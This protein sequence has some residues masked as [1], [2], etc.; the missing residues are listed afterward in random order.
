[1][2]EKNSSRF[3]ST[4]QEGNTEQANQDNV[5]VHKGYSDWDNGSY[6][7]VTGNQAFSY[8]KKTSFFE[9]YKGLLISTLIAVII[10]VSLGVI[11]LKIFIDLDPEEVTFQSGGQ[12]NGQTV[13][14][15]AEGNGTES[16]STFASQSFSFF[17]TQAG[18]FSEEAK[19]QELVDRLQGAEIKSVTWVEDNQF[20]VLVGVDGNEAGS[21]AFAS[22]ELPSDMEFY[23][24]K[25][26]QI[27][28]DSMEITGADQEA[29]TQLES[30]ITQLLEGADAAGAIDQWQGTDSLDTAPI[31]EALEQIQSANNE[32]AIQAATLELIQAYQMLSQ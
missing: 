2:E 18:V 3:P 11:M 30:I 23:A 25:P 31:T 27:S 14:T 32:Q 29:L 7:H 8:S 19:A 17:V 12:A 28:S 16:T 26:W 15:K 1:M 20:H 13:T 9:K 10:G 24:G 4:D 6:T 21:K 22:S 5:L